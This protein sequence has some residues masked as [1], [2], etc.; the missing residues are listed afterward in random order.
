MGNILPH[1]LDQRADLVQGTP[2][3]PYSMMTGV[4]EGDAGAVFVGYHAGAATT[5]AVL[6]HTYS[7]VCTD[8]RVNGES[9][10][11]TVINAAI[12]GMKGVPVILVAGDEA[13]CAQAEAALKGVRTVAVK[14]AYGARVSVSMSPE[15]ARAA[16]RA[17]VEEAVRGAA[18][19]TPFQ[20]PPPYRLEM[21]LT[22]TLAADLAAFTPG[23]ERIGPLSVAFSAEEVFDLFRGFLVMVSE[24][25]YK[26][27]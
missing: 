12:A 15:R 9:W 27:Y 1:K 23:A 25:Q 19:V 24:A 17:G 7:G 8:V 6:D 4:E 22:S 5:T 16:L 26:P 2:K 13:C 14:K 11:E 18:T 3:V 21:D 20:P 10:N